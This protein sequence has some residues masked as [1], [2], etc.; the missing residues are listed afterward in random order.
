MPTFLHTGDIH[1]DSSF[2]AHF[3]AER[4]ELRRNEVL[5]CVSEIVRLAA[6]VDILLIAG[7]LFDGSRVSRN[8]VAYLKRKFAEI[9]NTR[10]FIAAG[11][12]DPYTADSVYAKENLG[13]NVHVFATTPEC[14]EI[15][16]LNTRVYGVSFSAGNVG[17]IDMPRIKKK[18]GVSDIMLLHAD[19]S[20]GDMYNP[21]DKGFI[22]D[23]GADY[24]ALGHIHKRTEPSRCGKTCYTYCGIP[25]GRG[26]D[27]CGDMGCYIGEISE[28][29]A[30]VEFVRTCIKRMF[31]LTV[32]VS[33]ASDTRQVVDIIRGGISDCGTADDMYRVILTGRVAADIVNLD[34]IRDE[35]KNSASYAEFRDETRRTYNYEALSA[36]DSLCGEFIRQLRAMTVNDSADAQI[37]AMAMDMG[38]EALLGGD[39]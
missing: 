24:L 35:L 19:M 13:D 4:A 33:E 22:E 37:A 17:Y 14:V 11:N 36:E 9:P 18:V 2:S 32:D 1:L 15:P 30:R 16:E 20:G 31:R 34:I 27:E 28:G 26:F 39:A 10:I 12:H 8:T 29:T 6:G 7:D 25:E 5:R 23:C 21:I 3:S 38:I